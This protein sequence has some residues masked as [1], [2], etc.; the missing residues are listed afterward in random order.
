M[1]GLQWE[2]HRHI[3]WIHT[4]PL[5]INMAPARNGHKGGQPTNQHAGRVGSLDN[6]LEITSSLL[7]R[8]MQPF[9]LNS[10]LSQNGS[11]ELAIL[12]QFHITSGYS[13]LSPTAFPGTVRF[14]PLMSCKTRHNSDMTL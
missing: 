2:Y 5:V 10:E 13:C 1:I 4:I 14:S 9:S 3:N 6:I 7:E 12:G 11:T 8:V